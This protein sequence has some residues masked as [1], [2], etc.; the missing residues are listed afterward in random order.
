M[1]KRTH[2]VSATIAGAM[3]GLMATAL[4]MT[5]TAEENPS[6]GLNATDLSMTAAA[7]ETPSA[8]LTVALYSKY[9]WRGYELSKGSMVI[10]PTMSVDYKGF[11]FELWGNLDTDQDAKLYDDDTGSNWN[12]TDM[13]ISYDG[14][15]GMV[16]YSAGYIYYALDAEDD[17]QEIYASLSLDVI[18]APTLTVYRDMAKFPG[19]YTSLDFSHSFDLMENL[20]LGLG[21]KVSYLYV[22][23]ESTLADPT[24]PNSSYSAFHD[25]VVS[26]TLSYT[27]TEN[28]VISPEAYY[29][30]ALSSDARDVIEE[31]SADGNDSDFF[32]GGV[33]A[34]FSF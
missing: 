5:V 4:P 15:Y 33:S 18:T 3:I 11:G 28:L 17:T 2:L 19:W 14:S 1:K 22:D 26:L 30:F 7:E 6:A 29:S 13:T 9:V 23:D 21:A 20:A 8:D 32:Y 31:K 34:S 24:D 16:G 27:V 10:Q 25:G 12:E